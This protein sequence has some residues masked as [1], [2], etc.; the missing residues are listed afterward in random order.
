[1]KPEL[2]GLPAYFLLW[3]AAAL[4]GSLA[5]SRLARRDGFPAGKSLAAIVVLVLAIL[6]GSKLLYL[7]EHV[8]FPVDDP[9]S[10]VSDPAAVLL[11]HGF[12]IPGGILLLAPVLPL[13]CRA[14][15]LPVRRFADAVL[16]AVGI[17][18]IFI[19]LGCFL[20]GCCF[21][22]VS[23]VLWA[24]AFP[25]GSRAY[26]WQLK[27]GLIAWPATHSLP[28]Q[29][30]QI[31]FALIGLALYGLGRYWQEH[32]EYDGHV[33]VNS[34]LLF[35]GSTFLLEFVRGYS[36]HLNF[37]VTAAVFVV[38]AAVAVRGRRMIPMLGLA[39]P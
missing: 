21:G 17:G 30:L 22:K 38:T 28:V 25:R 10:L 12:R 33:W 4:C 7:L 19:R 39:M 1:M 3:G 15:G 35:F 16:P 24:I 2:F 18:I 9:G 6:A 36:L 13:V 23:N 14:L 34:Y 31:Y 29:P 8:V 32:K 37:I 5:A 20:N 11:W 26:A 27:Q